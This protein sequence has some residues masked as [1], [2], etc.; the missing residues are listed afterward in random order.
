M[1]QQAI[2]PSAL[3]VENLTIGRMEPVR[4]IEEAAAAGFGA[5]G[6]PLATA[7]PVPLEHGIV[8]KPA[9]IAAIRAALQRTGTRLFDVE[10]FV[11]APGMTMQDYRPVLEAGAELGADCI[12]VIGAPVGGPASSPQDRIDLF[13]ALCEEA[14]R[15]GLRVGVECM[16]Y[17][18]IRTIAEALLL[19]EAAGSDD[20]GIIL[21]VLH[22]HRAGID[23]AEIAALPPH[24]VAYA[25]LCDVAPG[26][27]PAIAALPTEARSGR[28]HPG[29]GIAALHAFL[30]ALPEGTA[31]A[32]ETPV[33]ADAGLSTGKRLQ[34]AADH[35]RQF[36]LDWAR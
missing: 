32:V 29:Q 25:Q 26:P 12:S 16:L 3:V 22:L 28:L 10:A 11:L 13:G 34:L 1:R 6:L 35:A 27:A 31:L 15:H 2:P 20:T 30:A 8:G 7:T 23:A 14:G 21:D 33:A 36:L 17:R 4:F 5:V 9:T 18:D 24:R 19:I